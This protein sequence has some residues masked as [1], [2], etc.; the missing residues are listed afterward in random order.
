ML[1]AADEGSEIP[2][3]EALPA[4]ELTDAVELVEDAAA[5]DDEFEDPA[6]GPTLPFLAFDFFRL[7]CFSKVYAKK[8]L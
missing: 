8:S 5:T 2:A 6:D 4:V 7:A 1:L 3:D